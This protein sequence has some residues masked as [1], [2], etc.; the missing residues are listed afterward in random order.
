MAFVFS[1]FL[2]LFGC[3]L[4]AKLILLAFG[5]PSR[6]YLLGL[7]A[8]LLANVYWLDFTSQRDRLPERRKRVQAQAQDPAAE[9]LSTPESPHE[10]E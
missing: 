10:T 9:K 2:R 8:I 6:N 7:T 5:S 3:F 1:F 4:A